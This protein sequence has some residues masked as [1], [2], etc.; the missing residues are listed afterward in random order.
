[1]IFILYKLVASIEYIMNQYFKAI[2][3]ITIILATFGMNVITAA[4]INLSGFISIRGGS[5]LETS[6]S[7]SG[8]DADFSLKPESLY[9]LQLDANLNQDLTATAQF[10]ARGKD[11]SD[12]KAEWLYLSYDVNDQIRVTAGRVVVPFYMHSQYFDVG[13]TYNWLSLPERVYVIQFNTVEGIGLTHEFD[14]G[15]DWEHTFEFLY[16]S[17]NDVVTFSGVTDNQDIPDLISLS[18]KVNNDWFTLRAVYLQASV[19]IKTPLDTLAA[20]ASTF[21]TQAGQEIAVDGVLARFNSVGIAIDAQD[22]LVDSEFVNIKLDERNGF[23]K[24]ADRFYLS[25]GKRVNNLIP[26]YLYQ[27]EKTKIFDVPVTGD[28]T[29]DALIV[30]A[31]NGGLKKLVSH[32]IGLRYDFH[33]SAALKVE[34]KVQSDKLN[35][36][37]SLESGLLR[38]SIDAVF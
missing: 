28:A 10:I 35:N 17:N 36:A 13:Y 29:T 18:S 19:T 7:L 37:A 23:F 4:E 2:N 12:V 34:Y 25:I 27:I 32:S 26:Y 16:G 8:Y 1:M 5:T 38:F 3:F 9:G 30:T 22:W 21:N 6:K 31:F 20:T 33:P 14:F 24:Q 11:D 15:D